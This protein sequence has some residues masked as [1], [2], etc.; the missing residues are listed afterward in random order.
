MEV[1]YAN[2]LPGMYRHSCLKHCL[3]ERR[4]WIFYH[5]II[6]AFVQF[7]AIAIIVPET[8]HP[9]LCREKAKRVRKETRDERYK[10]PI[11]ILERS[12]FKVSIRISINPFNRRIL[13]KYLTDSGP[14]Y[15]SA[16]FALDPRANV[17]H[18]LPVLSC[19]IRHP[20]SILWFFPSYL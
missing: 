12:V 1:S 8:Y 10:A 6:W 15:I 17:P 4:R 3:L 5:L 13:L 16:L 19:N 2:S 20:V 9:V 18:P 14:F 11:E 7:I